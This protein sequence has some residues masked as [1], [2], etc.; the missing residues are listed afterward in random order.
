MIQET[1]LEVELVPLAELIPHP[2]NVRRGDVGAIV[3]S[4]RAH[5]QYRPIVV[6]QSTGYVIAGNHTL[7]AARDLGWS[8]LEVVKIDV[9]DDEAKRIMLVDNRTAD[10]AAYDDQALGLILSELVRSDRGLDGTGYSVEQVDDLMRRL[11]ALSDEGFDAMIE[12][13]NMP[14]YSSEDRTSYDHVTVHFTSQADVAAFFALIGQKVH[15]WVWWPE[16]DGFRGS[17]AREQ[18]VVTGAES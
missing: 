7:L 4:L 18:W 1:G 5:G 8:G 14:D 10:L 9:D 12:W 11:N 3:E 17:D 6:Q 13:E 16:S 15:Q 2:D